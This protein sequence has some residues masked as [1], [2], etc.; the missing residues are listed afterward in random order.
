MGSS[1]LVIVIGVSSLVVVLH[2]VA[3]A[4][5]SVGGLFVLDC[6]AR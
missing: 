2:Q 3:D 4:V 6:I 1:S 5:H